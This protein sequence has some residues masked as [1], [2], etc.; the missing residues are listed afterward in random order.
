MKPRPRLGKRLTVAQEFFV[1]CIGA[2]IRRP[3][4]FQRQHSIWGRTCRRCRRSRR[5]CG[6]TA[7]RTGSLTSI[8]PR[9]AEVDELWEKLSESGS[10][11]RCGWLKDKFGLSWQIA[12]TRL[13]EL[14]PSSDAGKWQHVLAAIMKMTKLDVAEPQAA[15]AKS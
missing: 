12:S 9:K 15:A 14:M 1:I 6:S 4:L 7:R 11:G 3:S 2:A 10:K 13:T 8:A 5:V